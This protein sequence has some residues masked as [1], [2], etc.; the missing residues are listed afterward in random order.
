VKYFIPTIIFFF[1]SSSSVIEIKETQK[2]PEM[3]KIIDNLFKQYPFL[4]DRAYCAA[5][6]PYN[7][8]SIRR[9]NP[10]ITTALLFVPNLTKYMIHNA[11]Q[12]PRPSS[13]FF[14]QNLILRWIIDSLSMWFGSPNG[15]KFLGADIACIE[16]HQISQNFIDQY[17]QARVIVCAWCVNEPEQRRWLKAN[18]VTIIT[19]TLFDIDLHSITK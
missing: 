1:S 19:D 4:Y 13:K 17:K 14:A 6:H 16:H 3:A 18:G 10:Y 15:L 11:N 7:L 5:F 2:I 8:Y 9:L 12:T